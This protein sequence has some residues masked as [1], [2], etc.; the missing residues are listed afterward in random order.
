LYH[1]DVD[2][3]FI[4]K[5]RNVVGLRQPFREVDGFM[6]PILA[7]IDPTEFPELHVYSGNLGNG[8]R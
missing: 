5:Q 7:K 8:P 6:L 3:Q 2:P 1:L 4:R